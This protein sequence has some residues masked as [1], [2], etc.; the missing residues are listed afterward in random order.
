MKGLL[1]LGLLAVLLGL[2]LARPWAN[3]SCTRLQWLLHSPCKLADS[4]LLL[5][6]R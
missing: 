4:K 1:L 2:S 5:E 3:A 6:V